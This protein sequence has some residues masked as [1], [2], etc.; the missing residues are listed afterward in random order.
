MLSVYIMRGIVMLLV[1]PAHEAAHAFASY[2][3]GDST[4][5]NYGR[6]SLNPV[7]HFDPW[8]ALCMI[9]AGIGWAKPVPANPYF[10]KNPKRDM[11]ISAAA[12]PLCNLG[13]AYLGM[14]ALKVCLLF[15][16]TNQ[17][18]P[19]TYLLSFLSVFIQLNISLAVFNLIPIPPFDGSR[20]ALLFLPQKLYFQ[21]MQYEQY[22]MFGMFILV[23]TGLLDKPLY[24]INQTVYSLLDLMSRFIL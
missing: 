24:F 10:F 23:F 17:F 19:P 8:G 2:K 20:I 5:K 9:L 18:I 4:A 11:A 14:I 12:G 22:L 13:L 15:G 1:I 3:L 7:V 21:I 16:L 6:M